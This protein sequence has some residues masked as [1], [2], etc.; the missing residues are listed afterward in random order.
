MPRDHIV[1]KLL[2]HNVHNQ[3]N[4]ANHNTV[5]NE[6]RQRFAISRIRTL[7]KSVRRDCQHCK[8]LNAKPINPE[9]AEHP[10]AK[11][12][13][14]SRP[15]S[16]VGIDYFGHIEVI[17]G[18]K[19]VK[20]WGV[21]FTCLTIRA[22]HLEVAHS[23]DT[24]SCIMA[25]SNFI[26]RRGQPIE[27]RTDNGTNFKGASKVLSQEGIIARKTWM[28]KFNFCSRKNNT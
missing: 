7:V 1:T 19:V 17:Q 24:N 25:L 2:V 28:E 13:A 26:S 15:F 3:L 16:Y 23:L 5:V 8:L 18:R 27:I 6:L 10:P 21:L 22:I 20:R 11:L 9:M 4:H 14:Y 12:A